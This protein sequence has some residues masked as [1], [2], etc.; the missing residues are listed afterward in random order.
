MATADKPWGGRFGRSTD[1]L[2]ERFNAS[3]GFDSRL[4]A[5]DVTGSQA[6]ARALARAGVLTEAECATIVA[7]LAQVLAEMSTPGYVLDARLEDIHMA[8]EARLTEAIGP[9]GGKLHTGRSRNDQVNV[10]ERLY[11]RAALDTTAAGIRQLQE[12]LVRSAESHLEVVVPGYTHLQQAQPILFSHY[13]LSLFWMLERDRGRLS[14]TWMRADFL[15]LGAGALAGS[16][17]PL[18]RE[19]LARDLGFSQ[20]TANSLDAVADRDFLVEALSALAI[21]VMHLSRF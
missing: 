4:L 8:V 9:L 18:D 10:D 14:D 19:A 1:E 13:A 5:V 2:M 12:V 3:I 11:L 6:Y 16:A 15:P 7:G 17:F 21:L 20:A